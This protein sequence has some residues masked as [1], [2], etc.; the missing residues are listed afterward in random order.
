MQTLSYSK[1]K[2]R[3]EFLN[4][5]QTVIVYKLIRN[6]DMHLQSIKKLTDGERLNAITKRHPKCAKQRQSLKLQ[7]L[8]QFSY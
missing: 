7:M 4:S 2:L 3:K 5:M 6:S 1:Q 8:K